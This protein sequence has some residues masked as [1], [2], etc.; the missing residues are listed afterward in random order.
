MSTHAVKVIEISEIFP[1]PNPEVTRLQMTKV[2]GWQCVIGKDVNVGDKAVY[3]EP[4]YMCPMDR[5]EFSFLREKT[6]PLDKIMKR[7]RVRR[8]KNALSQ[9]LLI[10]LPDH[11]KD[12]PVGSDVMKELG[13]ERYIPIAPVSGRD[14]GPGPSISNFHFDIEPFQRYHTFF[15]PEDLVIVTEKCDGT[16]SKFV[17]TAGADGEVRQFV[18]TRNNWLKLKEK[19]NA[20]DPYWRCFYQ[21]PQI[22]KWCKDHPDYVLYG[23]VFGS[24]GPLKYGATQG[25]LFLGCFGILHNHKWL[26]FDECQKLIEGYDLT[27][28]PVVYRGPFDAQKILELAEQDS[29]W[30]GANHMRE[31]VVVVPDKEMVSAEFEPCGG[32]VALKVVSNRYLM[33]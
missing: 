4:D 16:S 3:I 31:G 5:P 7:I 12:R 30:P 27:W 10:P 1:H 2:D 6:D 18:G 19:K 15:K 28:A 29:I 20:D 21:Y 11:L 17:Y 32:R 13:I 24:N 25:K 23:E 22:E 9:G 26:D 14:F 33:S 8:F